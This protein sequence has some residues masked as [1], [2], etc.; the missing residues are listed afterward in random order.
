MPYCKICNTYDCDKH[1]FF[2]GKP[3]SIQQFA[4][5]SPP[6]IFVGRWNYPNIYTGI[7]SPEEYGQT[8]ELSSPELWH[9][10]KLSIS[11]ILKN[12]NKL[13]YGRTQSNIKKL[14]TKFLSV[15]KEVAMT[16]KSI[17]AEF[18]L[19]KPIK[20]QDEQSANV[21]LISHAAEV[22]HVRLQ[23][24]PSVKPKVEYLVND[25]NAKATTAMLE[26]EKAN[27]QT[28]SITKL[29]S[30]GLLGLR[31]NR[32]LVPTRW[33]I[34]AVDDT[35]S[36][37]KLKRIRYFPEIQ[38]ISVFHA[39]FLGNHYEFLLLPSNW[40]FEVIEISLKKFGVWQDHESFFQRK[41]YAE[42]VTGAYY[43][44][45]L[46]VTEYLEKIKRQ[47]LCLVFREIRPEYTAPLGVGILRQTSR[48]AF[49][50]PPETFQSIQEALK[51][52]Q[53]R[54]RLHVDNFAQKSVLLKQ[55]SQQKK[56]TSF[57]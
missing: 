48:E 25:T 3:R 6:E 13:I 47:A 22:E 24:N 4:G 20:K 30:A 2:I 14:E 40:S 53:T 43:A 16:D 26:L 15:M 35:L 36:K 28:S 32:K 5:S 42:D 33:S 54:L 18:K 51:Q 23:E 45:R 27:I 49:S 9:K 21:P 38:E 50:N 19:K 39:E 56:L 31:P 57:L 10:N 7:L 17:A 52:I 41:T 29:L 37:E 55:Q 46:A 1:L 8:A 11:E 34:T 12:R 44:N